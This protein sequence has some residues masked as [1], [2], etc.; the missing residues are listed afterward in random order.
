MSRA[1]KY[2]IEIK[3]GVSVDLTDSAV[4]VKGPKGELKISLNTPKLNQWSI[5]FFAI[6]ETHLLM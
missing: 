2:P 5:K 4:V 3:N 1:G 6:L